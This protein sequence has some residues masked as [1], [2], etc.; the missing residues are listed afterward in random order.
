MRTVLVT[1]LLSSLLF[2]RLVIVDPFAGR[3][4]K[5]CVRLAPL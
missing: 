5:R 4:A 1:R 2:F 3:F